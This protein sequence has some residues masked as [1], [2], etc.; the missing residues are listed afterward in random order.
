MRIH[1]GR[2]H[3]D[4]D[5]GFTLIE[6]LVVLLIMGILLAIAIP[7]FL[8]VTQGASNTAAESNL[9]TALT[10][11]DAYYTQNNASY[12]TLQDSSFTGQDTSLT[13]VA[14]GDTPNNSSGAKVISFYQPTGTTNDVVLAAWS[15]GTS[16]CYAIADIK[17]TTVPDGTNVAAASN[18]S[19]GYFSPSSASGC[20]AAA[21]FATTGVPASG[22]GA[23]S[24]SGFPS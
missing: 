1:L 22:S 8:S 17:D 23:W 18:V 21:A 4:R 16:R 20:T 11:A 10:A 6:L 14:D 9:Q 3:T 19:Y 12:G 13:F 15:S 7:T 5:E 24:T 2:Y